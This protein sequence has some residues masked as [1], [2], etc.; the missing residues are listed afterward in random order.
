M[1]ASQWQIGDDLTASELK[2]LGKY[3]VVKLYDEINRLRARDGHEPVGGLGFYLK[4][5]SHVLGPEKNP[6][7]AEA[8]DN[9]DKKM[10]AAR[11]GAQ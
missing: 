3:P 4:V 5:H 2:L 10:A 7:V 9:L 1:T 6:R 8:F 11:Q